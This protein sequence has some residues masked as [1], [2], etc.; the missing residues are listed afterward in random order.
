MF[1]K[2]FLQDVRHNFWEILRMIFQTRSKTGN[3]YI[4]SMRKWINFIRL[5]KCFREQE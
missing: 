1:E 5:I 2:G 4:I 3:A